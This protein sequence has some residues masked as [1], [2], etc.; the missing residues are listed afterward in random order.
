MA[1]VWE[2][3]TVEARPVQG[4][5]CGAGVADIDGSFLCAARETL[6]ELVTEQTR[7]AYPSATP[8]EVRAAQDAA[9]DAWVGLLRASANGED[10]S[11]SADTLGASGRRYSF[12]FAYLALEYGQRLSHAPDF[13]RR[14]ATRLLSTTL[15][16]VARSLDAQH[17]YFLLPWAIRQASRADVRVV[18][19]TERSVTVEWRAEA[20]LATLRPEDHQP[21]LHMY[22][23]IY[24]GLLQELPGLARG[25]P[26]ADVR[27]EASMLAGAPSF[28]WQV[29]WREPAPRP[30]Y[31]IAGAVASVLLV[32]LAIAVPTL[33]FLA[34]AALLPATAGAFVAWGLRQRRER[35][36]AQ[37]LLDGLHASAAAPVG[38]AP[39]ASSADL[40]RQV[41]TLTLMHDIT[42]A[43][44]TTLDRSALMA[45]LLEV[46]TQQLRFDRA[47]LLLVDDE[48]Q[49][50]VYGDVSHPAPSPELQVQLEALL[51]PV[52]E[53]NRGPLTQ[54][55]ARG[56]TTLV[57]RDSEVFTASRLHWLFSALEMSSFLAAPLIAGGRLVGVVIVDNHFTGQPIDEEDERLLSTVSTSMAMALEN[58]RLYSL[59]DEQLSARVA[60]LR[61]QQ[62][63]DRELN[64]SLQL[65]RVMTLTI[66]WALRFTN[67]A[68]GSVALY[69]PEDDTLR[70]VYG[71]GYGPDF[72]QRRMVSLAPDHAGVTGRVVRTGRAQLVEDVTQDPNYVQ[73]V[74]GIRS[75]IAVPVVLEHRVVGVLTLE[76]TRPSAFRQ[77]QVEFAGRLADRA[78]VAIENT[79]LFD[80]TKRER[81]KLSTILA[82]TADGVIVVGMDGRLE[83]VNV[84]ARAIFRLGPRA[85]YRGMLLTDVFADTPV[86]GIHARAVEW[87]RSVIDEITLAD[88]RTYH[89]R[90]S[91]VQ[92]VGWVAVMQ[93]ITHFKEMDRLKSELVT[94]VSHDLKNPLNVLGGYVEL[95]EMYGVASE[96]VNHYLNM[97]RRS[98]VHMRQLIDDLLDM[99]RI[100]SGINLE[101]SPVEVRQVFGE[102]M[103]ALH[104]LAANKAIHVSVDIEH[105]VPLIRADHNRLRQI[106]VNLLSNAIKYTPP[107]GEV[108]LMA[109]P[110]DN[111]VLI[112]V[113]DNGLGIAP[114]DQAKVFSRFYRVRRPETDSIEGT[115]LGLAIVKS[116]VELHGGEV[117]L[118]SRLGEGSTFHFTMPRADVE[119]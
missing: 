20:E 95:I 23:E 43:L 80:E 85:E 13:A 33:G 51:V 38:V 1:T 58:A 86:L 50:L 68:A 37:A 78:A 24:A 103:D 70:F 30:L 106:L 54:A 72:E 6:Q 88:S 89:V 114:E 3:P 25:L 39:D 117:G 29:T 90:I 41:D 26:R 14:A 52:E 87:G 16:P 55:W 53:G 42:L 77:D 101:L 74:P 66:D 18:A 61:I 19:A 67:A 71:Y 9:I 57:H 22:R 76:S 98:I 92:D 12:E 46:L 36:S 115:G 111:F 84:A 110:Q 73:M 45:R 21:Y 75:Q 104:T 65:D 2:C 56:E 59:T 83:L 100:E 94:T 69:S 105:G 119:A 82:S 116:L 102:A 97:I 60:E 44:G 35:A 4:A 62:Q 10:V 107:E 31:L 5:P 49:A 108:R 47:L 63:I 28:R 93:D 118:E 109:E 48:R 17:L 27:E 40:Q 99:A 91:P 81:E 96:R 7:A 8:D 11:F 15:L 112:S 64:A 113:S 34:W 32:L 79:R